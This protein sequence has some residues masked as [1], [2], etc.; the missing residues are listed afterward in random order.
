MRKKYGLTAHVETAGPV[1]LQSEP[2]RAFLFRAAQ[3]LLFNVVKHARVKEARI[4]VRQCRRYLCLSV[5][6]RGRG[7]DP[8]GLREAAGFGL[9]NIRERV[10]LLGGRMKIRSA[11]GQGSRFFLVVPTAKEVV[12]SP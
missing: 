2:L 7:F 11:A 8:Q 6:D 10:E 5:S 12:G 1:E 4:R 3:E 9:L